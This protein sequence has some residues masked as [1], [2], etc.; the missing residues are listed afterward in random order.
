[1]NQRLLAGPKPYAL[2]ESS[3]MRP[4]L[5]F[6]LLAPLCAAAADLYNG[7]PT[8][9]VEPE[10]IEDAA[11]SLF[12]GG[13]PPADRFAVVVRH[14]GDDAVDVPTSIDFGTLGAIPLTNLH[15]PAPRES[16]Q[17]ARTAEDANYTSAFQVHCADA[18]LFIN[19]WRFAP[20]AL[21]DEGPHAAYG[22]AFSDPPRAFDGNP[23][24]NLV[25]QTELE[26]PWVYKPQGAGIAQTYFQIRF[27]DTTTGRFLQMTMLLHDTAGTDFPPYADYA[28]NDSLF[29]ATPA[30]TTSVVTRSPY[31]AAP[32]ARVWTGLRFFR[33]QITPTNFRAA[34]ALAN[35]FCAGRPDVPDCVILPG[36]P[37]PLSETPEDYRIAEFA[38]ITE[39]FNA[40]T[41]RNGLSVGLHLRALGL[42]NFR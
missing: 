13:E 3:R 20:E 39:L 8:A 6:L 35:S 34:V 11:A 40:D 4:V 2:P 30:T 15:V 9:I 19:A 22:F 33:S 18:G 38:L 24:T 27:Y 32:S 10:C 36:T 26:V 17:R 1:M 25:I 28:R 14:M 29:V 5:A 31:S 21:I 7:T 12:A 37:A 42:Y 41:D 16:W 23:D